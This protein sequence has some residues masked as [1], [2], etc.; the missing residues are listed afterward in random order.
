LPGNA[1]SSRERQ[2]RNEAIIRHPE[3]GTTFFAI[4]MLHR[5]VDFSG[6]SRFLFGGLARLAGARW[7]AP[8]IQF[9]AL[10]LAWSLLF[11]LWRRK[12]FVKV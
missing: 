9:G 3:Q 7:E 11:W 1:I 2:T 12:V 6:P 8:L 4:Y 5:I 10:L